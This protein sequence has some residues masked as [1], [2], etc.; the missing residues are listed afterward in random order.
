[1]PISFSA[2]EISGSILALS[3]SEFYFVPA[4]FKGIGIENGPASVY[5]LDSTLF[6]R[7]KPASRASAVL[8]GAAATKPANY[9]NGH[10]DSPCPF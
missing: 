6:C 4:R 8:A 5:V 3:F 7:Q 10:G 2:V 9:E 1:M